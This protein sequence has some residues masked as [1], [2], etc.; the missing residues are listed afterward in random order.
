MSLH[1]RKESTVAEKT[2]VQDRRNRLQSR[3]KSFNHQSQIFLPNANWDELV[4]R[5]A[6]FTYGDDDG[7]DKE[8]DDDD[9]DWEDEFPEKLTLCL[10]STLGK[11]QCIKH[12]WG[13]IADQELGLRVGEVDECLER[14]R[15]ALGHKSLLLR[16]GVRKAAGQKGKTR[17]WTD[18][19][20]IENIIKKEVNAYRCA[21]EAIKSL[22][23]DKKLLDR[24]EA[25]TTEDL[26][27]S[28]DV[29]E[30]SRFG[31]RNDAL[32]WFWRLDGIGQR[33]ND[34]WMQECE[35]LKFNRELQ[36]L[37]QNKTV[38][39]VNWHRAKARYSRWV[40]EVKIVHTE[41][42]ST[43]GWFSHQR[44]TW[45]RRAEDAKVTVQRGHE[46]YA[47]KQVLMWGAMEKSAKDLLNE[48]PE[49]L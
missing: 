23:G 38:Y 16:N 34:T 48:C 25:I 17:A 14:L 8:E 21:R 22:V 36:L 42:K 28:G 44:T 1:A 40:E 29:V 10:P 11:N 20:K 19:A 46:C 26:K 31:Q 27:M 13:L 35:Y 49:N 41:I 5:T 30:E 9:D 12:G 6:K 4:P 24:Y 47:N 7:D 45:E 32:A 15:L 43:V 2:D 3:I 18:V 37:N 33:P 39:R